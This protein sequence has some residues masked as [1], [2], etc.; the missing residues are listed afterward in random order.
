M[1]TFRRVLWASVV[2]ICA[3]IIWL[4]YEIGQ[5]NKEMMEIPLGPEFALTAGDGSEITEAALREKPT[6]LFFGFTHCP[7][8]C[9]TTLYELNGW[10]HQ[11]DPDG[12]KINAYWVTVDPERD[13]PEIMHQYLSNVSDRIVGISGDPD[14][15]HAMIDGFGIYYKKVPLDPNEPD[16][17]YTMDHNAAVF[18]LNDGG[19]LKGT[20]AYSENPDT[21][22][23]KLENLIKG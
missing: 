23:Q 12:D 22:V 20:I 3:A 14:K 4:V 2:V 9:P 8:V 11:V 18:L 5:T 10:L 17:D 21:A 19:V 15:V 13:T 1:K 16:G 7:E 6:A